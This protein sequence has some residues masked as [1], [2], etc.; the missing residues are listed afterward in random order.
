MKT[1]MH[2]QKFYEAQTYFLEL[3]IMKHAQPSK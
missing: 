3:N 2:R 1:V